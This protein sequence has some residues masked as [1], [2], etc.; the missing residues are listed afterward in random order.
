MNVKCNKYLGSIYIDFVVDDVFCYEDEDNL[1]DVEFY[2]LL[3][4][5]VWECVYGFK[6]DEV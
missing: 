2:G 5:G 6:E 3:G 4:G 1:Y